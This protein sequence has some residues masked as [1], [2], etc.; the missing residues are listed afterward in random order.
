MDS[1]RKQGVRQ[2]GEGSLTRHLRT[3]L[4]VSEVSLLTSTN[5]AADWQ[6]FGRPWQLEQST[7]DAEAER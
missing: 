5:S 2:L 6:G 3:F 7:F 1:G 4:A